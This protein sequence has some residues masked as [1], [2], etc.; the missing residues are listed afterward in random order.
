VLKACAVPPRI[1]D[2]GSKCSMLSSLLLQLNISERAPWI[3]LLQV[4]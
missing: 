4:S 3:L 2:I 1:G